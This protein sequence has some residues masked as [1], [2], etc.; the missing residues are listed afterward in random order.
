VKN[1]TAQRPTLIDTRELA[2]ELSISVRT[3][4]R[5]AAEGILPRVRIG[6]KIVR[7]D[8]I[9]CRR[10]LGITEGGAE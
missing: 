10:A 6:R 4:H 2:R 5:Y 7:F 8:P 9:A 3:V 1:T